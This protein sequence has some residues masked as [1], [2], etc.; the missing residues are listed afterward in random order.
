M[1][2]L[3]TIVGNTRFPVGSKVPGCGGELREREEVCSHPFDGFAAP[4]M[5]HGALSPKL[6]VRQQW[7]QR[8]KLTLSQ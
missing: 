5:G 6:M 7:Q 3:F 4:R 8:K 2:A 1:A